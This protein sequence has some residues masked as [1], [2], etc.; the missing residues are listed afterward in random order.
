M[1]GPAGEEFTV[2]SA[3]GESAEQ[4]RLDFGITSW[5]TETIQPP[6]A[7]TGTIYCGKII[8]PAARSM[9]CTETY[10]RD[11]QRQAVITHQRTGDS[12]RAGGK[13]AFRELAFCNRPDQRRIFRRG[14]AGE[15]LPDDEIILDPLRR[16]APTGLDRLGVGDGE[17]KDNSRGHR[18]R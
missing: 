18:C 17:L 8:S 2:A 12:R 14:I 1:N 10:M 16:D 7:P 13:P 9:A 5:R 3:V 15:M 4:V 6:D 11:R